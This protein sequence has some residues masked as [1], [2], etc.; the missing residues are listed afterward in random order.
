[1]NNKA[2]P[3]HYPELSAA[4]KDVRS[5]FIQAGIFS[6]AINL[7]ML[8]PVMYM[9]Q[10]FNRVVSSGSLSTLAM[11]TLLMVALLTAMG[12]FEWVRSMILISASNR[13]E[14]NLRRRVSDATF[15][16]SL[17]TGGMISNAQPVSDLTGLRQFLTG[18]GLFAFFDAPWF[19]IYVAVMFMFHPWFGV[20]A[21]LA[22]IIMVILAYT[23]ELVTSKKLK[24]AN[25]QA[26]Q[27]S[28]RLSGSLRNAEVIAAMGMA[29]D[30]S[31]RQEHSA[32][33]MLLLQTD[34]SK[35]AGV[36]TSVSKSFRLIMQSMLLGMGAFL[37]VR[38]DLSPGMMIAGSL[39]LGRA[40]APIDML[41]GTWKAFVLARAQYDRLGQLLQNIPADRE[42]MSLPAPEGRLT[43]EQVMVVPP[44]SQTIVARGVSLD[45][46][47]GEALGIVGPSASG[48][49]CLA[50]A[51]LGIWPTHGGT[52]RLDGAAIA[53]W[54][55]EELGPYLGY[56]PQD[57]E[58]F[59]GSI[60]ENISRFGVLDAEKVV[61]AAK[62]VGVHNMILSLPQGYDTVIGATGGILSGGQ[63]Q[64]IGM[65]R[66]VYGNPRLLV[67]D[68]PNSNLDDQGERELVEA[69][70]RIKAQG[71]T[72]IIISHR[73]M[74]LSS[75]DKM[76][77]MKEGAA[78]SYGPR[79]E[80]LASLMAPAA[81]KQ[82]AAV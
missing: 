9:L 7:L 43:A 22:G 54:D 75:V 12:G 57:I 61:E 20:A 26:N 4:L 44:G 30:I 49:S 78:I 67:L 16:R 62:L 34:A 70:H 52:V 32:D 81:A 79:K 45:L 29:D 23:N 10:V 47:P 19:P 5:Y 21:I 35:W 8:V 69:I 58:L 1:M 65:A 51:L 3:S 24:D 82:A 15:K 66:A 50:R 55:R 31:R 72:A 18:N 60:S 42:S 80:V 68:E 41:V 76:L 63:R 48:K 36:L 53:S 11:L 14:K 59:D 37:V 13:L 39:L 71:C 2:N 38:G 6:A 77:V 27:V 40:L 25:A 64:R 73:T 33:K 56:L 74:V 28:A 17:L 46:Q